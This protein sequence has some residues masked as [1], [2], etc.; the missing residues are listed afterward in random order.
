[1]RTKLTHDVDFPLDDLD[2]A[3]Y[4]E[5]NDDAVQKPEKTPA[6][7]GKSRRTPRKST[8][9][10]A[11]VMRSDKMYDLVAVVTHHGLNAGSGHYTACAREFTAD[12]TSDWQHFNDDDVNPL[13]AEE[14]RTGQGYIFLYARK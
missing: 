7:T 12:G 13:T 4:C 1:M 5:T 3:P 10:P 6:S 11:Q 9:P 2:L 8:I 14:V